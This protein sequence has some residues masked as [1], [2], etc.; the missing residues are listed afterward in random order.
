MI[1]FL[2]ITINKTAVGGDGDFNF[3]IRAY[4][5]GSP[6]PYLSEQISIQ[7][8]DGSGSDIFYSASGIGDRFK[9]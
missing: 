7:T 2:N 3:Q 4:S 1:P 9:G 8:T 6:V 5:V